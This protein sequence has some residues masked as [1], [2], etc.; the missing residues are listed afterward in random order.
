M[1]VQDFDD[2]IGNTLDY[3]IRH[4]YGQITGLRTCF[5]F[6][7]LERTTVLQIYIL[8]KTNRSSLNFTCELGLISIPQGI[9]ISP[10]YKVSQQG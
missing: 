5:Q 3:Q 10:G 2:K 4:V 7:K 6:G 8:G 9:Y 1:L